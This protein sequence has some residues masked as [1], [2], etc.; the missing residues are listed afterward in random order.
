MPTATSTATPAA[1]APAT[2]ASNPRGAGRSARTRATQPRG[3]VRHQ[4]SAP[5]AAAVAN[6]GPGSRSPASPRP[7][8]ARLIAPN[9]AAQAASPPGKPG[10]AAQAASG[11]PAPTSAA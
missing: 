2:T 5:S 8:V 10:A 1:Q 7:S 4:P 6:T 3:T 11:A 9:P